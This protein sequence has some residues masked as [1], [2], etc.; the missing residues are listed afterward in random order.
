MMGITGMASL[1]VNKAHASLHSSP[2]WAETASGAGAT[3]QRAV[4]FPRRVRTGE[5]IEPD[6]RA[7]GA[8]GARE[9]F[10]NFRRSSPSLGNG[11]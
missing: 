7:A 4:K 10:L 1:G 5:R 3:R 2:A 8:E 6:R 9:G 11:R